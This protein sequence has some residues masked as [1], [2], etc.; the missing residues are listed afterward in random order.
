MSVVQYLVI[1]LACIVAL[2]G[3]GYKG[4]QAGSEHVRAEYA[5]AVDKART[6]AESARQA[7]QETARKSAKKLETALSAQRKLARDRGIQL[8]A[9]LAEIPPELANCPAPRLPA[10]VLNDINSA[11]A[12]IAVS[13]SGGSLPGGS[14]ITR[15]VDGPKPSGTSP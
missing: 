7:D 4:Y 9:H 15:P 11:L 1:A 3:A 2:A 13:A 6:D 14:G 8:E 10:S 5:V 12:G